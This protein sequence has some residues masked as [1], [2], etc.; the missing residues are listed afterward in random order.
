M[1]PSLTI[2]KFHFWLTLCIGLVAVLT[3]L[4]GCGDALKTPC[5][6][7][8]GTVCVMDK[9]G[10]DDYKCVAAPRAADALTEAPAGAVDVS[11]Q[12]QVGQ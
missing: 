7:P 6:C 1:R 8:L 4:P 12:S 5:N 3:Y 10:P 11:A 9:N 2:F